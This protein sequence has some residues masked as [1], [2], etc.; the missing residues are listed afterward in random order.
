[1]PR[2]SVIIP[3]HNWA[4]L[5]R[6]CL[7]TLLGAPA[8]SD[9][10]EIVVVDDASS[11]STPEL[12]A[13]Y[14]DRVRTLRHASNA[15]FGQA[16]NDGA[17]AAAAT[18]YLVFLNNDTIPQRGWLG[19][20]VAEA[21][22][23]PATA[24]VGSQLLFPN[25]TI[26]HAGVV[27][28][29]DRY[30]R[31]IYAGFPAHH[32]AVNKS[33]IFQVV[34]AACALFRRPAF[35]QAGGFETAFRNGYEDVDLCLRLGAAGHEVRY[36]HRSVLYHLESLSRATRTPDYLHNDALYRE[37]WAGRV[38]PDDLDYYV[39]DG[40]LKLGY[41]DYYPIQMEIS[42]LLGLAREG[43]AGAGDRILAARG[44]QVFELLRDNTRLAA[45]LREAELRAERSGGPGHAR[46]SSGVR[47]A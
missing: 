11:D 1:M 32:P 27:I 43:D 20:L 23:H 5:T 4:S 18:D 7:D 31:H 29:Q 37:R 45:L 40:L 36:C 39:E 33:R 47:D 24:V 22:A 15:G 38:R 30:P 19:A 14:G 41:S 34:T 9:D 13:S 42:P 17:A 44:R 3:V 21:D 25:G 6:Q 2:C 28:C 35:E 16:C 26:Q 46:V 10:F 8:G 12:L